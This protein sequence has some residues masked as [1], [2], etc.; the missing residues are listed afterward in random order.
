MNAREAEIIA[1]AITEKVCSQFMDWLG[2]SRPPSQGLKT[3]IFLVV[4][5][6]LI[7][8]IET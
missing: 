2:E 8:G 5:S 1:K 7:T 3:D 4:K 6:T